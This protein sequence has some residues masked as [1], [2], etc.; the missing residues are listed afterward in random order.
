VGPRSRRSTTTA[1]FPAPTG[2]KGYKGALVVV[3]LVLATVARL[4][5]PGEVEARRIPSG[6]PARQLVAK[7][8]LAPQRGPDPSWTHPTSPRS[9]A[10]A[11][12]IEIPSQ[13]ISK[14]KERFVE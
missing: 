10:S 13:H 6:P 12:P 14:A 11:L 8:G 1:E 3:P 2:M 9:Y 4:V 7:P 5:M